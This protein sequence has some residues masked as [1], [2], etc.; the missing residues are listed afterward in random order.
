MLNFDK[1]NNFHYIELNTDPRLIS[2]L[3]IVLQ[4]FEKRYNDYAKKCHLHMSERHFWLCDVN[5]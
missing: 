4:Q 2:Q 3:D 5:Q 1:T